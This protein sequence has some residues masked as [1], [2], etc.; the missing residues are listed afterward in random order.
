MTET[1]K[2]QTAQI[3]IGRYRISG[4][5]ANLV[6]MVIAGSLVWWVWPS[7]APSANS[8]WFSPTRVSALL[9]LGFTVYWARSAK[10]ASTARSSESIKSRQVHVLL[11][12]GS[13]LLLLIPFPG[14]TGRFEP[15]TPM[16]AA[17]GAV[18]QSAFLAFAIWARRHLGR[19]WSGEV[20]VKVDHQLVQSGPYRFVR[21]PIYT[22]M[23]GMYAGSA[24]AIG[25][26]H[27]VA[28]IA[29]M[30]FAYARKIGLE[31]TALRGEFGEVYDDYRRKSWALIPPLW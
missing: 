4:F 19:N 18:I 28:A 20:T 1:E 27:C 14:L 24:V 30:L 3:A 8:S 11:L 13:L 2:P 23:A 12:N 21:H 25:E 31:E 10:N 15:D 26:W 17:L 29:I 16:L 6:L 9:W 5:A 7:R 22:A